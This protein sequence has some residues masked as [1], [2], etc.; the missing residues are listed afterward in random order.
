[1][2]ELL[3]ATVR[4]T[5]WSTSDTCRG[6]TTSVRQGAVSVASLRT[7][8]SVLIGAGERFFQPAPRH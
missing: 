4:G 5:E 6:T 2:E 8:R 3:T 1:M 7:G